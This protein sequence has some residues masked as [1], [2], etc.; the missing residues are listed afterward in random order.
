MRS[1]CKKSISRILIAE[2]CCDLA[3]VQIKLSIITVSELLLPPSNEVWDKVIFLH[4]SV[5]L[6]IGG[7]LPQCM[8]GYHLP[9]GPCTPQDHAPPRDHAPPPPLTMH[10][11]GTMHPPAQ[12]MLGDTVNAW[13]VRILLECNLVVT[14]FEKV[15]L[16]SSSAK[17]RLHSCCWYRSGTV[18]SKSFVGKVLLRIKQKF[19]L[20]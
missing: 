13:A 16:C 5:I 4:L 9:P 3:A 7:C 1:R 10:P 20:N 12:S 17:V 11:T 6:F 19:E 15:G 14:W 18:N 2:F 8:L